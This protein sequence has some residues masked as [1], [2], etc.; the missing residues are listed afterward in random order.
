MTVSAYHLPEGQSGIWSIRHFTVTPEQERLERARSWRDGRWVA[1]GV[2]T[3]LY[4]G[5]SIIMSDTQDELRDHSFF[6]HAA[7]GSVLINGLGMGCAVRMALAKP[8]VMSATAT[9]KSPDVIALVAP[10]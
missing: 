1:A 7:T 9:E 8:T 2:Y 4:R 5:G 6:Q 10:H 3:G